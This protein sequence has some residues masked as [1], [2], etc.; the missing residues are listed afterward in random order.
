MQYRQLGQRGPTVS[1]VGL[2]CNNFGGNPVTAPSGTVYGRTMLGIVGDVT[3]FGTST[4]WFDDSTQRLVSAGGTTAGMAGTAGVAATT[5]GGAANR[6][7]A[8]SS[9]LNGG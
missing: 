1:V 5:A 8:M 3:G 2:G 9:A 4:A 6:T 7:V